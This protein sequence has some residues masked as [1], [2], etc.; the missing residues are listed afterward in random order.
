MG[1]RLVC[2]LQF[3]FALACGASACAIDTLTIARSDDLSGRDGGLDGGDRSG[4]RGQPC[5]DNGSCLAQEFCAKLCGEPMGMCRPRPDLEACP[6]TYS[7]VCGCEDGG[8]NGLNYFN[9]CVRQ[10]Y[11]VS[12][13]YSGRC[14]FPTRCGAG[15]GDSC[16]SGATCARQVPAAAPCSDAPGT[17]WLLPDQCGE[18]AAG[19]DRWNLCRDLGVSGRVGSGSRVEPNDA[20]ECVDTCSAMRTGKPFWPATRCPG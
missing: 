9:D 20:I 8:E 18:P 19:G 7:P 15:E 14:E 1:I 16:P 17:C 12:S 6:T 10:A 11:G 3:V 2:F 5:A 4:N 13:F